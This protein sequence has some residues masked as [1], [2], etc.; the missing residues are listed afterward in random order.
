MWYILIAWLFFIIGYAVK[1]IKP[2]LRK[3]TIFTEKDRIEKK[4]WQHFLKRRTAEN[5]VESD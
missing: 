4:I 5:V 3:W 2:D 1:D